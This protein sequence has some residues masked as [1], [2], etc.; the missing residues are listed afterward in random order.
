MNKKTLLATFLGIIIL[1]GCA[2]QNVKYPEYKSVAT[3]SASTGTISTTSET[4]AEDFLIPD[5]QVF[6]S[7]RGG[8]ANSI[9]G[10]MFGAIGAMVSVSIDRS[11]NES[12]VGE[13]APSLRL[14][15]DSELTEALKQNLAREPYASKYQA[16]PSGKTSD[17]TLIPS[18]RFIV[19]KDSNARV[20]FQLNARFKDPVKGDEGRKAYSYSSEELRKFS[21]ENGWADK[22]GTRLKEAAHRPFERLSLVFIQ[23]LAGEFDAQIATGKQQLIRWHIEGDPQVITLRGKPQPV[24]SILLREYPDYFVVVPMLNDKPNMSLITVVERSLVRV[25]TK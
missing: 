22:N 6:I 14:K 16:L 18:A 7:G 11:R 19:Q 17:I 5:S 24:T 13:F 2:T 21:G 3:I 1:S 9:V 4:P 12:A 20:S 15:F 25:E 10:S 8:V 23:D